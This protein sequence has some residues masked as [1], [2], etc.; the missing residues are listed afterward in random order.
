[1]KTI[2]YFGDFR[3][4]Y[5]TEL[6]IARALRELGY[7]VVCKQE[8]KVFKQDITALMNDVKILKPILILFSKGK[9]MGN[10]EE[11][12][13]ALKKEGFNTAC[14][15]FDL[16]FDLPLDRGAGLRNKIAPFN[17]ATIFS[18]DGGHDKEFAEMDIKKI[19][20][21]QGIYEPEA[22]LYDREKIH[23]IIFVGND[24]FKTRV[25]MLNHLASKYGKRFERFGHTPDKVVR[26][27]PLNELYASTKVVVGDSQPSPRYWSNRIY[28]TLGR[29]GFLLH[30]KVEGIEE[31]FID[32]VHLVLY[33]R[34]NLEDLT[35]KIDYYLEHDDERERIRKQGFEHVKNNFTYKHRCIEL[36]KHYDK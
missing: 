13:E 31:E 29:G 27:L 7:N 8:G 19:T 17:S 16:Y 30:P 32:G 22:I 5:D 14:W 36:M 34:D 11:F 3:K 21:R 24:V 10:S 25:K 28:E 9:P 26:N 20:L 33:D 15:L 6:F 12:I 35:N 4:P 2:L 18:T 23:D 1:M